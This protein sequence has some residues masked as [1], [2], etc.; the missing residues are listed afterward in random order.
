MTR[1]PTRTG[2]TLIEL[3]VVVAI[4]AILLAAIVGVGRAV[5]ARGKSQDTAAM[6]MT[7]ELAIKQFRDDK[8]LAKVL[9]Y[10]Q[11]YTLDYPPDELEAFTDEYN[12][13]GFLNISSGGSALVNQIGTTINL[14]PGVVSNGGVKALALAIKL[15]SAAGAEIL[16]RIDGRFREVVTVAGGN[17]PTEILRR[18][19]AGIQVDEP[20]IYYVDS[21]GTPIDYFAT[22]MPGAPGAAGVVEANSDA[23]PPVGAR[24]R[25]STAFVQLNDGLPLLVSYGPDGPDQFSADFIASEGNTDLVADY[26]DNGAD[27]LINHRLNEDNVYSNPKLAEKLR[28]GA[29]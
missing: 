7:L 2:F 24:R 11:R 12:V 23:P 28:Q 29:P 19:V 5:I 25:A 6:L 20:L 21:W 13:V 8:P 26:W 4:I 14:G 22:S 1:P 18:T 17:Q 3:L 10:N 15:Y 16:E 9:N 27:N